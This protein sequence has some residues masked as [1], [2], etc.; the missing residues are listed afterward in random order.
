MPAGDGREFTAVFSHFGL[1]AARIIHFF[2]YQSYN[3]MH[4]RPAR[5]ASCA[6]TKV[7]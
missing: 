3:F 4:E 6:A 2:E 1:R 7:S 5:R